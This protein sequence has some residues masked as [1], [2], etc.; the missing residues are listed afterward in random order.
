MSNIDREKEQTINLTIEPSLLDLV[1]EQI[2]EDV[3]DYF[4]V[5]GQPSEGQRSRWIIGAIRDRL[6][7]INRDK[8]RPS[9]TVEMRTWD[10]NI[11]P[12]LRITITP[13][14]TRGAVSDSRFGTV[15][16][17]EKYSEVTNE[18]G[19]AY[20]ELPPSSRIHSDYLVQFGTDK[21]NT[22]TFTMPETNSNLGELDLVKVNID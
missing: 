5:G 21:E 13:K 4:V 11:I 20:F 17:D 7:E 1:D 6:T 14:E 8:T 10:E 12:D 3:L 18:F 9:L 19:F 22:Y 15:Y 16:Y 2:N